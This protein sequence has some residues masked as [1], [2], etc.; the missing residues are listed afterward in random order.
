MPQIS[1]VPLD[2]CVVLEP[3][4]AVRNLENKRRQTCCS[5]HVRT[6]T[7]LHII[8]QCYSKSFRRKGNSSFSWV[9]PCIRDQS[10]QGSALGCQLS[11][12]NRCDPV[13]MPKRYRH[14]SLL[15][16]MIQGCNIWKRCLCKSV[17]T[18]G[19]PEWE[20]W[21]APLAER[22]AVLHAP[23]RK[24][25]YW[26]IFHNSESVMRCAMSCSY[27]LQGMIIHEIRNLCDFHE[28]WAA[29]VAQV[30]SSIPSESA[31][32]Y[33]PRLHASC[34]HVW[35]HFQDLLDPAES[36]N[37]NP[38]RSTASCFCTLS[39]RQRRNIILAT[40]CGNSSF[41]FFQYCSIAVLP[42]N[43]YCLKLFCCK[44]VL[45][46]ALY[47]GCQKCRSLTLSSYA[48]MVGVECL[49]LQDVTCLDRLAQARDVWQFLAS[50]KCEKCESI[51]II[52]ELCECEKRKSKDS[53]LLPMLTMST[54]STMV[55]WVESKSCNGSSLPHLCV[56]RA[57]ARVVCTCQALR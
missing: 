47:Q 18:F 27:M 12:A 37:D 23:N 44:F 35:L 33:P 13:R 15:A 10:M 5:D 19:D 14:R 43:L 34:L 46:L 56:R 24:E 53:A 26:P 1:T 8:E 52:S 29:M 32:L 28:F 57:Q 7:F 51:K 40:T 3:G 42:A 9:Q 50:E 4:S 11:I 16:L 25:W 41:V 39:L 49:R 31:Y 48:P 30:T 54:M 45:A 20:R 21:W 22:P 17:K 38:C 55:E 2:W 36:R 6:C